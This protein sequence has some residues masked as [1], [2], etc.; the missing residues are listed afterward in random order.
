MTRR[1]GAPAETAWQRQKKT[2]A[3]RASITRADG[4]SWQAIADALQICTTV[5]CA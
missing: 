5:S 1:K 4:M 3:E 2:T